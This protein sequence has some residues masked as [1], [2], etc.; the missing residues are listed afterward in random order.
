MRVLVLLYKGMLP[1]PGTTVGDAQW[2]DWKT[3]F[4]VLRSLKKLGHHV[5]PVEVDQSLDPLEKAI[6]NFQPDIVFN[7]LEEF[8]DEPAF[9]KHIVSYLELKDIPYT[10]CGPEG[11]L[12]CRDKAL[13]KKILGH[14]GV[15]TPQFFVSPKGQKKFNQDFEFK[16]PMIVKSL[17]EEASM[18]L[19]HS[20]VVH[21]QERLEERV[22]FIKD[23]S[24]I[25][26]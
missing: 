16:F 2:E 7:L 12:L 5:F 10:G 23:L 17:T 11:L 20:S 21:N 22:Q 9:D 26:I 18:G 24:L 8:A 14:H 1:K 4:H 15:K 3:E 13:A 25:H 6:E 19:S